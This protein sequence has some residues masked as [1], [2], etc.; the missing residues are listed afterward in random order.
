[1]AS[2]SSVNL[3]PDFSDYA[4]WIELYNAANIS[5]NLK[6]YFLSDNL[7]IPDKWQVPSDLIIPAKGYAI[8]W[9]DGMN[10]GIHTSYK[11]SASGE[12]IGL[13][14]PTLALLDSVVFPPQKSDISE[15]RSQDGSGSWGYFTIPTPGA[16]NNTS[17]FYTDYAKNSV[18]FSVRGGIYDSGFDLE[19]TTLL[20]GKIRYTLDGTDPV[21]SSAE[22]TSAI[23]VNSNTIVKARIFKNGMIPGPVKTQSYFLDDDLKSR[24]LP[25]VSITTD[26]ANFWDPAKGIYVQNFKPDWE[27]P[28]NIE[29]FENNGSD[30]AAFNEQVGIKVNGLYS[31]QLPQKMLGI[32]FKGQYGSS[33]LAYPLLFHKSRKSYKDFALRA[34]GSDWSYTMFRDI[35]GQDGSR[36]NTNLDFMDFRPSIL[37][38]NGEYMGIHNIRE[39]VDADYIEKNHNIEPGTFDM[40]ENEDF[41]EA[42]SLDA[43]NYLLTLLSKDLSNNANYQAVADLIDIENFSDLVITEMATGNSSIDHNVMAWKPKDSGKWKWVIMDLDRGFFNPGNNVM[44]FYIQ[45]NSFP[46]RELMKNQ[47]FKDYFVKRLCDQLYTTYHPERMKTLIDSHSAEIENEI[48]FH[49]QRWLGRTSSYGNAMPSVNYWENEVGKLKYYVE[50]RPSALLNDLV[51]YGYNTTVNLFV[52]T[53]PVGA[54]SLEIN[55]MK[56]PGTVWNGLYL[57]GINSTLTAVDKPGYQFKGWRNS[58]E[59]ILIPASSVWKYLDNGSDQGT[60]WTDPG[61]DDASWKSGQAQLGYGDGDEVTTISYGGNSGS[62]YITSYFRKNFTLT[63]EDLASTGFIISLLRDDGAVVYINGVEVLRSNLGRGTILSNSLALNS[64]SGNAESRFNKFVIDGSMLIPGD[65]LIAVELHQDAANSSDLSFDL[66]LTGIAG[67]NSGFISTSRDLPINLSAGAN[68][69]AYYEQTGQCI[70]PPVIKGQVILDAACSPY[71]AQG[72]VKVEPGSTLKIMPGVVI[73]MPPKANIM[74]EGN[75]SAIGTESDGITIKTDPAYGDQS[76]GAITF[77][78]CSDTSKLSYVTLE[79]ASEGE[80]PNRDY[81][82]ISSFNA[83]LVLDHLNLEDVDSNP[84]VCR[85][86][87]VVLTNS[88]LAS[89]VSGDLINAKYGTAR[90]ENSVFVGNNMVDND[91]IDFDGI[92]NGIIRNCKIYNFFG[93]NCDAIDIGEKVSNLLID[94]VSVANIFDKGVSVGQNSSATIKHST[95]INCTLGMGLKDLSQISIDHCSFYGTTIAVDCYEKNPGSAGG[96]ASLS[97]SILSNSSIKS[98]SADSMSSLIIDHSIS[99]NTPLPSGSG[100]I[101]GNPMFKNPLTMDFSLQS[102]S[103]ALMTGSDG[104]P[105]SNMGSVNKMPD[106]DPFPMISVIYV[107]PMNSTFPEFIG[108]YNPSGK[109]VDMS[110]YSIDKGVTYTFPQGIILDAYD[111]LYLTSYSGSG[112]WYNFPKQ[113]YQWESGKLSDNGESIELLDGHGLVVDYLEYTDQGGW[114]AD[115]F[116]DGKVM[117]LKSPELDNHFGE[118]W[119]TES[120]DQVFSRMDSLA[121][122]ELV[123]YPNPSY[124]MVNILIPSNKAS[125]IYI[126]SIQGSLLDIVAVDNSGVT[127]I[128][129]ARFNQGIVLLKIGDSVKKIVVLK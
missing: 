118:N 115:A 45:Q 43:Y 49:V 16:S 96:I 98:Y 108:I 100:N 66:K 38:V 50:E 119:I 31:W 36:L 48:P 120:I 92:A 85:Y 1:M 32:Y 87:D 11:L 20:G 13:Y 107:N 79:S 30:R 2:N 21:E 72:D 94:S 22:Y 80:I 46:F 93:Y 104:G 116:T 26:P 52:A 124:K 73:Y 84:I 68:Y 88:S 122:S 15:G 63:A 25:V 56:I 12:E 64:I 71:Y 37:F 89:K 65:N 74:V 24:K 28:A 35:L 83:N 78:N 111:M 54:G 114:P 27:I 29:L 40:V 18:E 82:A 106:I 39:K 23:S 9:T 58:V 95:F 128:D 55:H 17:V 67:D 102:S 110:G 76:W 53:S 97:N 91:G 121:E 77:L 126:Y 33:S 19:L 61:Y 69:I 129:V 41:A 101:F 10:T 127:E 7:G 51:N 70:V 4:D 112:V 86:S 3:D 57:R 14:S 125:E 47:G 60:A 44:N 75:I 90:V 42:G 62:K 109:A 5:V 103:P 117:S 34:S 105:S 123:V 6:G 99:D 81:A 59:K 113:L 8:I